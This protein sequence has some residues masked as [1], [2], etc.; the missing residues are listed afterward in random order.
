MYSLLELLTSRD[1]CSPIKGCR[2]DSSHFLFSSLNA[3][4]SLNFSLSRVTASVIISDPKYSSISFKAG[5]PN[6]STYLE[7]KS[8]STTVIP[9]D[10]N[11][12]ETAV[13]PLPMPPVKPIINIMRCYQKDSVFSF[14]STRYSEN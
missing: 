3:I 10:S 5:C 2:V 1:I 13:F 14:K 8:A 4:S 6:S 12:S 7:A 9:K 11:L